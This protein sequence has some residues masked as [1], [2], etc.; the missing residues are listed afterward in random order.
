MILHG[1]LGTLALLSLALTLWQWLA[2]RRFPLHQ[3]SADLRIGANQSRTQS[4]APNRNSALHLQRVFLCV[5]AVSVKHLA[6]LRRIWAR[7]S[8]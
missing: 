5:S 6:R 8:N 2:A 7:I 1:I 3:R 4:S